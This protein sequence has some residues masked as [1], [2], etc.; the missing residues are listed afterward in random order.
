MSRERCHRPLMVGSERG[1]KNTMNH[2]PLIVA[3]PSWSGRNAFPAWQLCAT[4]LSPS[5]HG[6]VGTTDVDCIVA[7]DASASPSPHGRVGTV[8]AS[9]RSLRSYESPSPHGRV[10]TANGAIISRLP[11]KVTVPSWSGRNRK[12]PAP[13]RR[14]PVR[15]RPLMVGSER[16]RARCPVGRKSLVTVPSWSGRNALDKTEASRRFSHRPLMVGS[17]R[18]GRPSGRRILHRQSPSPHGRVGTLPKRRAL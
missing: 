11:G 7:C 14:H 6:R 18:L 8:G 4:F 17:E 15:H 1:W 9:T 10:G 12:V 5:P 2:S 13:T 3:V 16:T